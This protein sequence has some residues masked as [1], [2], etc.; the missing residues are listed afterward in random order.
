MGP[1]T[2]VGILAISSDESICNPLLCYTNGFLFSY[3][4]N[5][6]LLLLLPLRDF[7]FCRDQEVMRYHEI[8]G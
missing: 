8:Y 1:L 4:L 5:I 2:P 3:F 6:F 7:A